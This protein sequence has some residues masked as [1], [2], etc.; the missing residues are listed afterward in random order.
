[1]TPRISAII[2]CKNERSHILACVGSLESVADEVIVA[3]SGSTDGTLDLVRAHGGC[4]LIE[5]EWIGYAR[6]K[7]WAIPQARHPW[8]LLVDA[9]ERVT[10][11]LGVEIR[12]AVAD[13]GDHVDGFWLPRRNHFHGIP[14]R[15]SG[16]GSDRVCR[17]IRRDRCRYRDTR[18]HEEIDISPERAGRLK[19]PLLHFTH[20]SYDEILDK[21]VRYAA[22]SAR[23]AYHR[24]VRAS[25]LRMLTV[26]PL[27]FLRSYLLKGGLFDGIAG[28]QVCM[29]T[30]F[31]AYLKE[32]RLWEL[33]RAASPAGA[34]ARDEPHEEVAARERS[35]PP[36]GGTTSAVMPPAKHPGRA[37]PLSR[38]LRSLCDRPARSLPPCSR[39]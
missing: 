29:M 33:H 30:A 15:R 20:A 7:N 34:T 12:R 3:D 17:L 14:I 28:L 13:A 31:Y 6:F 2:P 27:R 21:T 19:H 36:E 24:G 32:A 37:T 10:A 1:M 39:P 22:L 38:R 5:H 18:V 35:F 26:A 25:Y 11:E 16:W 23:D 8:V 4:R 9:D